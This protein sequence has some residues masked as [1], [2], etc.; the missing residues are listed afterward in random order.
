MIR[1]AAKSW[2]NELAEHGVRS[3]LRFTKRD[4]KIGHF[5]QMAWAST[6]AVGCGLNWCPEKNMTIFI[7]NY[8]AH[9]NIISNAT[10]IYEKGK[11]CKSAKS[12]TTYKR[13]FCEKKT[14][15]CVR[16]E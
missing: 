5:T 12:C 6:T 13:S 8:M 3:D 14:G 16:K 11:P 10:R 7:C 1:L 15:L 9:G 2:W 4:M